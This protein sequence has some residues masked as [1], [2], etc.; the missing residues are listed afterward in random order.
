MGNQDKVQSMESWV[1]CPWTGELPEQSGQA[2]LSLSTFCPRTQTELPWDQLSNSPDWL[3]LQASDRPLGTAQRF[4]DRVPSPAEGRGLPSLGGSAW[5][6]ST[7]LP[8]LCPG[9][10]VVTLWHGALQ[11]G[12]I[13]EP[14]SRP[15]EGFRLLVETNNFGIVIIIIIIGSIYLKFT[16]C[17]AL[18][19]TNSCKS[20]HDPL[21][22]PF[23]KWES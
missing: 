9:A 11:A 13:L 8:T 23:Y 22:S 15:S 17:Q 5:P 3:G 18:D 1:A 16:G 4:R 6:C 7:E 19:R 12:H 21:L 10:V 20:H 14:G 2:G